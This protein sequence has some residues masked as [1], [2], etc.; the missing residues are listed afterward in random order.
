MYS[1][2]PQVPRYSANILFYTSSGSARLSRITSAATA[3]IYRSKRASR[4][5]LLAP[6]RQSDA[7]SAGIFSRRTNQR[8]FVP[9]ACSARAVTTG[10]DV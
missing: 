10:A 1:Y 9:A 6:P 3:I 4:F 5:T 7:G 2:V 8:F